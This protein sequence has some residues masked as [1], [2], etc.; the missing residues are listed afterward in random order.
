MLAYIKIFSYN[1][2]HI[3]VG[4]LAKEKEIYKEKEMC[5]SSHFDFKGI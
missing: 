5:F 3:C 1:G 2:A 4:M